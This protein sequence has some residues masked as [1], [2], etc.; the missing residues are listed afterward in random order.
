[1]S[2][3]SRADRAR[4]FI[5]TSGRI[6]KSVFSASVRTFVVPFAASCTTQL[7]F[8]AKE[9]LMVFSNAI[10]SLSVSGTRPFDAVAL[11]ACVFQAWKFL[12]APTKGDKHLRSAW[13]RPSR[14]ISSTTSGAAGFSVSIR[15]SPSFCPYLH[16]RAESQDRRENFAVS[17]VSRF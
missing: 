9:H 11:T 15:Q 6:L 10:F 13:L 8:L 17:A 14:S 16:R 7:R 2:S 5:L 1:M 3:A 12:P 4:S